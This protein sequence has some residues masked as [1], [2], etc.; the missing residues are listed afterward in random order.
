MDALRDHRGQASVELLAGLPALALA[1]LICLQLLVTGYSASLADGAAESGALALAAGREPEDAI[2]DAL[3]G[4]ADDRVDVDVT[5]SRLTVGL[6]P[7][8]PLEAVATALEVHSSAWVRR[9]GDGS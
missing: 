4:W 2:H 7:P 6:R 9:P 8:A 1:G 5:G 3:P